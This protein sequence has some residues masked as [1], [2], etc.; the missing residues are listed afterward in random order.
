MKNKRIY[1]SEQ[2][3]FHLDQISERGHF[4]TVDKKEPARHLN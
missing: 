1:W 4:V 3:D 2:F